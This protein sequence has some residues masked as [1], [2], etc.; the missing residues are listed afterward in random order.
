MIRSTYPYPPSLAQSDTR[1]EIRARSRFSIR[2]TFVR[3]EKEEVITNSFKSR[4]DLWGQ[5][6]RGG[7]RKGQEG[8]GWAGE[9]ESSR[10]VGEVTKDLGTFPGSLHCLLR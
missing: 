1:S 8:G 2:A 5:W 9:G 3:R 4:K 10:E 6:G 7:I